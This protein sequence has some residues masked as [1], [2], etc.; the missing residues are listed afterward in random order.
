M[1]VYGKRQGSLLYMLVGG[2][3]VIYPY[4]VP[5]LLLMIM[6]A[7]ILG[8]ALYFDI[9]LEWQPFHKTDDSAHDSH[10]H[11]YGRTNK[12]T[13]GSTHFTSARHPMTAE[14]ANTRSN[15]RRT[16]AGVT[17]CLTIISDAAPSSRS[18][19]ISGVSSSPSAR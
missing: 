8:A 18:R 2:I 1:F 12:A 19:S 10:P 7:V 16:A 17:S 13:S 4:F 6:I 9:R 5:S 3:F 11:V 14:N 15:N